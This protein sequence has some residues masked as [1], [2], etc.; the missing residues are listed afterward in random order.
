MAAI[1]SDLQQVGVDRRGHR[2]VLDR[3]K[4]HSDSRKSVPL[5]AGSRR[6]RLG[7]WGGSK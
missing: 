1:V 4:P 6:S 7:R 2:G 3:G 5:K